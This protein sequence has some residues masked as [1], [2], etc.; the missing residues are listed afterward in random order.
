MPGR[1]WEATR[2]PWEASTGGSDLSKFPLNQH[3]CTAYHA[4]HEFEICP[5]ACFTRF[6]AEIKRKK[7]TQGR[8]VVFEQCAS[9]RM[10]AG[11]AKK[12]GWPF[13]ADQL[14]LVEFIRFLL[15]HYTG[16]QELHLNKRKLAESEG[17][18]ER[19]Q[20]TDETIDQHYQNM[21]RASA[22]QGRRSGG[23]PSRRHEEGWAT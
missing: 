7:R 20:K 13:G 9:D 19:R 16:L 18:F 23:L 10:K 6:D 2:L 3:Q 8:S 22:C 14:I 11:A 21:F 1:P 4:L 12:G 15:E 17:W 5:K